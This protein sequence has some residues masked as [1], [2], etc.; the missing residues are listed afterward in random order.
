VSQSPSTAVPAFAPS[1]LVVLFGDRFVPEGGLMGYKEEVLTSGAKVV[2]DKLMG[3]AVTAALWAV[4]R[5][6]AATLEV[7]QAKAL[8]GLMKTQKLHLVRGGGAAAFPAHS[9]E[10]RLVDAAGAGPEVQKLLEEFIG[11][12]VSDPAG[13]AIARIKD[14]LAARGLLETAERKTMLVFTTTTFVLPAST[15][16]AAE[17]Q[18]LDP[19][20]TLLRDAEREPEL[21]RMVQ[22]AIDGA[23][24]SMTESS[25]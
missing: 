17:R 1:E 9:L 18:P 6:G 2:T 13:H 24:V 10:D 25:D 12:E 23:R 15:R 3:A 7:R 8:F 14:G 4:H 21:R 19:V 22:K 11:A 16:A 20:R 5:S